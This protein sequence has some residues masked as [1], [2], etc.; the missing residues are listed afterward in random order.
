LQVQARYGT[1]GHDLPLVRL[2]GVQLE[3]LYHSHL[4]VPASSAWQRAGLNLELTSRTSSS[5]MAPGTSL[6][7]LNT[8]RLAPDSRCAERRSARAQMR[9]TATYLCSLGRYPR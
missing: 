4:S 8:R 1:A 7:F 5:V 3:T 2:D 6:L 9:R